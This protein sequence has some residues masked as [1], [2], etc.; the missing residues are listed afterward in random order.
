M[1]R[2]KRIE[3]IGVAVNSCS[4]AAAFYR[5]MGIET[6][7]TEELPESALTV[8]MLPIGESQIELLE[9]TGPQATVA[10]FL[11]KRGEGIHHLALCVEDIEEAVRELTQAGIRMIDK[12]PRPGANGKMVAF[13]HPEST[14]GVLLELV[15]DA[16]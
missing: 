14:H 11:E 16:L 1:I 13:V 15:Q 2:V 10:K 9:P 6:S 3:H 4:E 7:S 8:A 12:T 5:L